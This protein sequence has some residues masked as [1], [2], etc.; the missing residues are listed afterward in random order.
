MDGTLPLG[1]QVSHMDL[2]RS[3]ALV[4]SLSGMA[5]LGVCLLVSLLGMPR[6]AQPCSKAARQLQ[7]RKHRR[8]NRSK[9]AATLERQPGN[10][11]AAPKK[12]PIAAIVNND[13][14]HARRSG[15]RVLTALWQRKFS[16]SI[17][18]QHADPHQLQGPAWRSDH[19]PRRS[20]KKST[21]W[22]RKFSS[23]RKR[24]VAG[25][26]LEKERGI[27]PQRYAQDIRLADVGV[28]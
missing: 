16:R 5:V 17:I 14:T 22:P 4:G 6:Q 2:D 11:A 8:R 7:S 21:A 23:Y 3:S 28:A 25:K 20:T 10:A 26:M 19:R 12:N 13:P 1:P 24:P 27:K 9:N 18:N 15:P